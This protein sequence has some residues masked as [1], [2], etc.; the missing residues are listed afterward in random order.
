MDSGQLKHF[1]IF[2]RILTAQYTVF[3]IYLL[4]VRYLMS[5]YLKKTNFTQDIDEK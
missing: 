1:Y 3:F 5:H 2:N 4:N